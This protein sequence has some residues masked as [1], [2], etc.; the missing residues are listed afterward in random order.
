MAVEAERM[1]EEIKKSLSQK[2][3]YFEKLVLKDEDLAFKDEDGL[4]TVEVVGEWSSTIRL[5]S[6]DTAEL[7]R[8]RDCF[9]RLKVR[10][11]CCQCRDP[12]PQ[13]SVS[14]AVLCC[15]VLLCAVLCCAVL[16][17]AVLCCAVL[18]RAVLCSWCCY[19]LCSAAE[20]RARSLHC[21]PCPWCARGV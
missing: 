3:Q 10:R 9:R 2:A 15:S 18:C 8:L 1:K 5:L 20:A 7:L 12:A 14:C 13:C 4:P 21:R 16:C 11:Q 6:L 19:C 17:C